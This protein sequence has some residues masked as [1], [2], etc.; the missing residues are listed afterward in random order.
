MNE[1]KERAI[2]ALLTHP[3]KAKAA[4]AVGITVRTMH[5][6][7]DDPEFVSEYRKAFRNM[8]ED[9]TRQA[10]QSLQPAIAVLNEI[11]NDKDKSAS[12]RVQAAKAI[13]E[14]TLRLGEQVD[15]I[16]QLEELERETDE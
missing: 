10:Q 9:S 3:T 13:I 8:V 7:F 11:A 15:I 2:A 5:N 1:K 12:A 4:E 6:Y 14:C 16:Q